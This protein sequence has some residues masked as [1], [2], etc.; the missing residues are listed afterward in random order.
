MLLAHTGEIAIA[1]WTEANADH[2]R[3]ISAAVAALEG[4]IVETVGASEPLPEGFILREGKGGADAVLSM[5][6]DGLEEEVT[7]HIQAGKSSKAV[8]V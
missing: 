3:L 1:V 8:R 5:L 6:S 2:S 7:G 4:E